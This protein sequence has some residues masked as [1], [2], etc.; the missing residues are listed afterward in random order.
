MGKESQMN[1]DSM[2]KSLRLNQPN[3]PAVI[4]SALFALTLLLGACGGS[5]E[6]TATPAPL[7]TA[8]AT[9]A[10]NATNAEPTS[11]PATA[12]GALTETEQAAQTSA[13]TEG[14]AP[15]GT[16]NAVVITSTQLVTGTEVVTNINVSTNTAVIEQNL[17]TTVI[18]NTNMV[19]NVVQSTDTSSASESSVTTATSQLTP[20][21]S[22]G[23]AEVNV[24]I[25]PLSPTPTTEVSNTSEVSA[26]TTPQPTETAQS[27]EG[28]LLTRTA[29]VAVGTIFTGVTDSQGKTIL[30]S[31]LLDSKFLT[32][33]GDVSG[34][35]EDLVVDV[36]SGQLLYLLLKYGGVLN[37]GE[38]TVAVPLNALSLKQDGTFLLNIPPEDLQQF[39]QLEDD[40][41]KAGSPNWDSDVRNFWDQE[42]FQVGFE[43]SVSGNAIR[44][45]AS[46]TGAPLNDIGLGTGTV[47][48][49]L[50][51]LDQ[52]RVPYVLVSFAN[53]PE[54]NGTAGEDNWYA[55][56]LTAFD[57]E[58]PQL[59]LRSDVNA[60][61]FEG[62]PRF[63]PN[64]LDQ[65]P[66]LPANYDEDWQVFWK[67]L[68]TPNP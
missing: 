10:T 47:N 17:I 5:S 11:E 39:P 28:Q 14:T 30:A 33:D 45:I 64:S 57:P 27:S 42:G 49:V 25:T 43:P 58:N 2:K 13:I 24:T 41:P 36:Q 67:K 56:P 1:E 63:D 37:A 46:W 22:T 59:A 3:P 55:V 12:N 51:A 32:S 7:P 29:P 21:S 19:S 62:A 60:S 65:N 26:T 34:N 9:I 35:L 52:G 15:S 23:Q 44:R 8:V 40:W 38:T 16:A 50:V 31:T 18:T 48:D 68:T 4:V 54:V 6:S 66:F 61:T 53:A 20:E